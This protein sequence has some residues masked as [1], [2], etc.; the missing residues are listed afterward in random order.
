MK[1]LEK[2][3]NQQHLLARIFLASGIIIA[4]AGVVLERTR[5]ALPIDPR[6]ITAAGILLLGLSLG[7]WLRYFSAAKDPQAAHRTVLAESDERMTAIKNQAGQRGFW[8]AITITYALLMWESISA[9]GS[10]PALS[11]DARWFW[12]AAAVVLPM[13][14][15]IASIIQGNKAD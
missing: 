11:P 13:I 2:Y 8:S 4:A 6:L 3:K 1:T 15:Y 14:V 5:T 10:L 9:N 7:S 12:L